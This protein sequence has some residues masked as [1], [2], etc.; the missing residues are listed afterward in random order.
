[1]AV[2]KRKEPEPAEAKERP[3]K[4]LFVSPVDGK[5]A[6]QRMLELVAAHPTIDKQ[7][8]LARACNELMAQFASGDSEFINPRNVGR[9]WRGE[10]DLAYSGFASAI[11]A[12]L[13]VRTLWL[14]FGVPPQRNEDEDL[15]QMIYERRKVRSSRGGDAK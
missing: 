7:A 5:T 14:Q 9:F 4:I 1:M 6:N 13:G 12:V 3:P 15:L 2:K 8:D 11:A 10:D